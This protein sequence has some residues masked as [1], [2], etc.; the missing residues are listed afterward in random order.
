MRVSDTPMNR[1]YWL[2]FVALATAV[3]SKLIADMSKASLALAVLDERVRFIFPC[4]SH[5]MRMCRSFLLSI[6]ASPSSFVLS[7]CSHFCRVQDRRISRQLD[8]L[9]KYSTSLAF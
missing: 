5:H 8:R 4:N 6:A 7:T 3:A 1:G 9:L 2:Y